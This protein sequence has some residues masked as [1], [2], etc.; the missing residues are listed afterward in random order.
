MALVMRA[1]GQMQEQNVL[2]TAND[3]QV[4]LHA[5]TQNGH[6]SNC[7]EIWQSALNLSFHAGQQ[8]DVADAALAIFSQ[9]MEEHSKR[10][11]IEGMLCAY[12]SLSDAVTASLQK[13]QCHDKVLSS[14]LARCRAALMQAAWRRKDSNPAFRRLL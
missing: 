1:F 10:E 5:L 13:A 8:S 7:S 12:E 6:T 14:L 4:M 3:Y 2:P 9:I 11:K